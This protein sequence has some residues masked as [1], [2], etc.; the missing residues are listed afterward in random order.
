MARQ[1]IQALD[2][3]LQYKQQEKRAD[4]QEALAFMQYG[5]Q[6]R[7]A[8]VKE[9]GL[10]METLKQAN[11]Q[12]Q[13]DVASNFLQTSGLKSLLDAV[14]TEV[15][16]VEEGLEGITEISKLLKKKQYGKFD[17][18]N[19][20]SI[21]SALWSYKQ[22]NDPS[23]ILNLAN[24]IE[25]LSVLKKG[26]DSDKNLLKGFKNIS[27]LP[28]LR[29]VSKQA[30]QSMINRDKILEE[31]FDFATGNT[32]IQEGIG[33]F[34]KEAYGDFQ[35]TK[36]KTTN[37]DINSIADL[38][39]KETEDPSSEVSGEKIFKQGYVPKTSDELIEQTSDFLTKEEQSIQKDKMENITSQQ[40]ELEE[41]LNQLVDERQD[42]LDD[43]E[44]MKENK[45]IARKR[46]DYFEKVG[47][48]KKRL[49]ASTEWR[50]FDNLLHKRNTMNQGSPVREKSAFEAVSFYGENVAHP[51]STSYGQI[52]GTKSEEIVKVKQAI[53]ELERQRNLLA[54]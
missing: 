54:Q 21:A 16:G 18:N 51:F 15:E 45:D 43:Y 25:S 31:Q 49:E 44:E 34:S 52:K 6:K 30:Q 22:S 35:K 42:F 46:M 12:F 27:N 40:L 28:A 9:Y 7:A 53:R 17:K 38:I 19:S 41:S 14:P 37:L 47:D 39:E 20:Q 24:R 2:K 29:Q 1:A 32:D 48:E 5:M 33:M 10:R 4:V 3:I 11:Q 8:D 26:T 36:Q 13:L 23:T 50:N